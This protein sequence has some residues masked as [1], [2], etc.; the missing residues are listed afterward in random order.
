MVLANMLELKPSHLHECGRFQLSGA[1]STTTSD[2]SDRTGALQLHLLALC[3]AFFL[4]HCLCWCQTFLLALVS[5]S[6]CSDA[7][8]LICLVEAPEHSPNKL[9]LWMFG[10]LS[11]PSAQADLYQ[12][13]KSCRSEYSSSLL[14]L[15]RGT[16]RYYLLKRSSP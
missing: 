11:G 15:N 2:P 1:A 13:I 12:C 16:N 9:V 5:Q 4:H 8:R 14:L 3:A 6:F 10:P 7:S